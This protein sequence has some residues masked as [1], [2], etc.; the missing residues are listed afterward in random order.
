MMPE[1]G[2]IPMIIGLLMILLAIFILPFA[3]KRIEE[4]LEIFLFVMGALAITVTWQWNVILIADAATEPVA[5]SLA[6]LVA[7]LIFRLLESPLK[8][9]LGKSINRIGQKPFVFIVVV[10]LGFVS[11]IITSIVAALLLVAIID[12]V[13]LGEENEVKLVVLSCYSIGLGS[14][15]TPLGGPLA[16]IIIA[17]LSGAPLY[18]SFWFLFNN[19]WFYFVPAI[20][21]L[22]ILST[23]MISKNQ[24]KIG[25]L[26]ENKAETVKEI[27]MR[28][29]KI[30]LFIMGLVF[31]GVGFKPL[32]E[33]F[34]SSIQPYILYWINS[35]SAVLD[36]ATLA[37][38]EI[39]PSMTL[40]QINS[41]VL[42]LSIAGG[43]LIPGNIPNIISASKLKIR[44]RTWAR[45]G[46]P[47]G[48]CM[49]LFFFLAI[50]L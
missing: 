37:A 1:V 45:L 33:G 46:V 44:S 10:A 12:A 23:R 48:I 25:D 13:S 43:M 28:T 24:D 21:F 15:L 35:L 31:L 30:Y 6:V 11:S 27:L 4:E 41:A 49:M 3:V 38:A 5:I 8:R 47:L 36:N 16:A 29:A 7:G 20:I 2:G 42:G 9:N 19:L 22:G 17:K 32:M 50:I 34:M 26:R 14:V 39:W 18:V 40:T